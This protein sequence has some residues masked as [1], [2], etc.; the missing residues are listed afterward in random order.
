[1]NT[2]FIVTSKWWFGGGADLTPLL[3]KR[4][5]Q[6]D[7]DSNDFHAA[8]KAAC[9]RHPIAH[10]AKYKAWCDDY[11]WLKHRSEPRGIGGVSSTIIIPA[12]G[13]QISHSRK[14]WAAPFSTFTR[15][16]PAAT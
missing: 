14:R 5:T 2:R 9:G 8:L 16:S 11:F 1:M 6:E 10:Y 3:D 7:P 12:I 4:R 13:T 15:S